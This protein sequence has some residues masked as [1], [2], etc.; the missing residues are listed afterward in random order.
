MSFKD[1][2]DMA[3]ALLQWEADLVKVLTTGKESFAAL[4][5]AVDSPPDMFPV[6]ASHSGCHVPPAHAARL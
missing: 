1:A 3:Y 2:Q 4:H 6:S 5:Q